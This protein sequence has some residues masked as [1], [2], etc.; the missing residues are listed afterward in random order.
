MNSIPGDDPARFALARA[1]ADAHAAWLAGERPRAMTMLA[2]LADREP[3]AAAVWA[4]LGSYALE[5]NDNEAARAH[6]QNAIA[7]AP[8]DAAAWTNLGTALLRTGRPDEAIAAYRSALAIDSGIVGAHVN[9]GN[10]LQQSGDLDGAVAALESA[11]RLQPE[12]AEVHNNLGN[13]YK[14]QGRFD[15]AFAAYDTARRLD[16]DFR[17]AY[18]NL[19]A[20]TKLS[21]RHAPAEIF[22]LHRSFAE[23]FEP[24]WQAGYI[25]PANAPDPDRRLRIGYVSPDCHTAL[26]AFVEPVLRQHDRAR[27]EVFVYFNNPQP[28][29][30]LAR[31]AP[32][33]VR[34]MKGVPD[35]TVA[36]WIRADGIDILIDIAGHT[37]HNR[38]GVFGGKPA[39]VA[40]TWLDYLGTTGL[41]SIDYRLTDAVSDPPGASD[42][43]HSE[44]L[45]RLDPVQWCW[46]PPSEVS[47]P[48]PLPAIAAGHLTLGSFNNC[49]KITDATLALWVRLLAELPRARLV[50]VGVAPGAAQ[51]RVEEALADATG[52]V[53]L[54]PRLS[55]EAF[56]RAIAGVDIALDPLPF[57]GATTT[58]EA[59]WQGLPVVTRPGAT[60]ASRS[61]AS[62]L[63]ALRLDDWIAGDDDAYIAIVRRAG[64]SLMALA[65]LRAHL[66]ERLR[67][68]PLCDAERF[69]RA[70][71]HLL[72]DAWRD[73]CSIRRGESVAGDATS[74]GMPAAGS[75]RARDRRRLDLDTRL[76]ALELALRTGRG[77]EVVAEACA[78]IGDEPGWQAAQRAYL[79]V[80]FAWSRTQRGL[81]ERVFPPP[82]APA[83][84]PKVSVLVC[85]IDPARFRSVTASYQQRFAGYALEIVGVHDARSLAEAYN[86]AAA[87]AS[88]DVLIFSHDDIELV[89]P[90]FAPRLVGHLDRYDGVGVAGASQVTGPRW[91]HAGQ[92][93]I[94]GHIL[95]APRSN[96]RGVLLM[97]SGFQHP[98]S[99]NIRVLDG[100]FIAVRRHVWE[101]Q[102]FDAD[103]YDGFHLYDLDFTWR[104]SGAGARLAVP[105]DLLLFHSS[106]GKYD[107]AWRRYARRF[108]AAAG[109]DPL[110]APRPGGLQTR[111]E[112]PDQVDTLRAAMV[113][114]RY[115][116]PGARATVS[117][118]PPPGGRS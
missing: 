49:A 86:R 22:A 41:D 117:M 12:A 30:V 3:A 40:V 54:L 33:E 113:H 99:E 32:I 61:T 38:L 39:P 97:V 88:G 16:S 74:P 108:V 78:L 26:P 112:T 76:A 85:S 6:L 69:T 82:P 77:A 72:S 84:R 10:A 73:W 46:N 35:G 79:R 102:R 27:F 15:D 9:L 116:T 71:E 5:S 21:I 13:L 92:Q 81:V 34:V 56:R 50:I 62:I 55:P 64:D 8:G 60:S 96:V 14:D 47:V 101:A 115:G 67:R 17:P 91:G 18:S 98:V 42:A 59:L 63:T 89:T 1:L 83:R 58:L 114:F 53:Q 2:A 107:A 95:H 48:C 43:L 90:D 36:D 68:S 28:A 118:P 103:R 70:L 51:V 7:H 93:A 65:D 106:Q 37:G 45:L 66:P 87:R 23:R 19:L 4:R 11:L 20:L 105:A 44:T 109:L 94:H 29:T 25:P 24:G 75:V 31:I 111:L 57:S 52:R 100:V 104:A 110:A 80:L